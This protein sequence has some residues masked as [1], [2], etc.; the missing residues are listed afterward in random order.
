MKDIV[1]C[2][3]AQHIGLDGALQTLDRDERVAQRF[4]GIVARIGQ[5]DRDANICDDVSFG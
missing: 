1:I 5:I 4:A 2:I 3:T